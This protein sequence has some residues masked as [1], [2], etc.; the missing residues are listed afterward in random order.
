M[1][2]DKQFVSWRH[3]VKIKKHVIVY[4]YVNILVRKQ[5]VVYNVRVIQMIV[6]IVVGEGIMWVED[7]EMG[8]EGGEGGG[9]LKN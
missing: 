2:K 7:G 1:Q 3:F 6:E 9:F 8:G 4:L 5:V